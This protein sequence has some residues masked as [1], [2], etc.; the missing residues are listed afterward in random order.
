MIIRPY[1]GGGVNDWIGRIMIR[2]YMGNSGSGAYGGA[3]EAENSRG[4]GDRLMDGELAVH[5]GTAVVEPAF[6]GGPG[7]DLGVDGLVQPGM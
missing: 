5:G 7:V 2:P 3:E 6:V 1:R 4:G